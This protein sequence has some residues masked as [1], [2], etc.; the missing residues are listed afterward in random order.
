MIK[1]LIQKP[2]K[3]KYLKTTINQLKVSMIEQVIKR[4]VL[5]EQNE[6]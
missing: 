1:L 3:I 6:N 5:S 2:N 4:K